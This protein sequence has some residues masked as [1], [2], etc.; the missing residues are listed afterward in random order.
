MTVRLGVKSD[1]IENR[2]SFDWLFGVMADFH[3]DRL[4]M[5]SS[6]PTFTADEGWFRRLRG[7]AEKKGIRIS[8]VF[9]STGRW[10]AGGAGTRPWRRLR[11][12]DGNA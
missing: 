3:V 5:G 8:S 1:P 6:F 10:G 7:T 12:G 2:Y 9:T 11:V 4:Q